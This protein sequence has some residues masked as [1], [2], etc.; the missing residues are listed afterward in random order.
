LFYL[1]LT[2]LIWDGRVSDAPLA[3]KLPVVALAADSLLLPVLQLTVS[4][5][6]QVLC[7]HCLP[8]PDPYDLN[9]TGI[10]HDQQHQ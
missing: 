9:H 3:V 6:A 7:P 10:V 5:L 2:V 1:L 4:K 8:G